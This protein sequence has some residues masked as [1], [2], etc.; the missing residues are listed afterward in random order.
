MTRQEEIEKGIT[1]FYENKDR[2][3]SLYKDMYRED[4]CFSCPGSVDFAYQ[5]MYKD[6]NK[7][8]AT[9]QMKRGKLIDT[10]MT[11]NPNLPQG[12]FSVHNMTDEIARQLIDNGYASYFI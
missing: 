8:F 12:Q 4:I 7:T 11:G 10:T 1:Y 2:M 6:R 5:K 3:S 9:I